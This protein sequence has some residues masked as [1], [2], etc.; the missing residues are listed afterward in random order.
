[1]PRV[2]T[3]LAV[4][5]LGAHG[6]IHVLGTVAYLRLGEVQ[7]LAYKTT[8][9]GGRLDLGTAGMGVFGALWV[10]PAVG[11]VA[12]AVG[13]FGAADW[14]RATLATAALVSLVLPALD[15][16]VAFAGV[17]V[18]VAILGILWATATQTA[19]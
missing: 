19:G 3:I 16:E 10:L 4:L 1:M 13:L 9:F 7:G 15:W 17:I 2:M 18:N 12:A 11:F 6:L 14:W 8:V 5:V